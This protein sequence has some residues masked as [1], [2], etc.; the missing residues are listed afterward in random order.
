MR[1]KE[2]HEVRTVFVRFQGGQVDLA[3]AEDTRCPSLW[4]DDLDAGRYIR[5]KFCL[6]SLFLKVSLER[7]PGNI[8]RVGEGG[9]IVHE[10]NSAFNVFPPAFLETSRGQLLL[11]NPKTGQFV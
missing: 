8:E 3:C 6:D 1:K 7:Y 2:F 4:E 9:G 10:E 5:L 11:E